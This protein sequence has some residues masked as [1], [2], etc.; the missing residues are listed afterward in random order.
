MFLFSCADSWFV[1]GATT[2]IMS[3]RRMEK[4]NIL[5][6]KDDKCDVCLDYELVYKG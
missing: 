2:L 5:P 3:E 1:T 4:V 6:L